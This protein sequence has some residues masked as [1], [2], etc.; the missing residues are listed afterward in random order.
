MYIKR[1]NL[2][3]FIIYYFVVRD[4]TSCIILPEVSTSKIKICKISLKLSIN[5]FIKVMDLNRFEEIFRLGRVAVGDDDV[6]G[7][8]PRMERRFSRRPE[9]VSLLE[10]NRLRNVGKYVHMLLH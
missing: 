4:Q 7:G 8:T 3:F 5:A 10:P 9:T 1:I 6:D 2:L